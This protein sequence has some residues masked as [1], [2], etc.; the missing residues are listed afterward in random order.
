M[1]PLVLNPLPP[2][3]G[4]ILIIVS[5]VL[6]KQLWTPQFWS[7]EQAEKFTIADTRKA[8]RRF[9]KVA[10]N[11][12]GSVAEV[13]SLSVD[14]MVVIKEVAAPADEAA[15]N[16]EGKEMKR[17]ALTTACVEA[18]DH[19]AEGPLALEKLPKKVSELARG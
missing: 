11:A 19:E 10:R 15:S 7:D 3:F 14:A 16:S 13:L 18:F 6:P 9:L 4:F 5:S 8:Y 17:G 2:P 12:K 1:L